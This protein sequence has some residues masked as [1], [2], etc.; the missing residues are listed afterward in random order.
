M[1]YL[2]YKHRPA[3][4]KQAAGSAEGLLPH[5]GRG[6]GDPRGQ[7]QAHLHRLFCF[8]GRRAGERPQEAPGSFR[9][10]SSSTPSEEPALESECFNITTLIPKNLVKERLAPWT[11]P[12]VILVS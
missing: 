9:R 10:E 4:L 8:P 3:G 11:R 12:E 1:S 2:S 5:L 7:P 6:W